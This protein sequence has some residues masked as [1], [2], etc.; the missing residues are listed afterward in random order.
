MLDPLDVRMPPPEVP[1]PQHTLLPRRAQER[2]KHAAALAT[3]APVGESTLRR[4]AVDD[5]IDAARRQYPSLF[6]SKL[7]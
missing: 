3:G 7:F 2:L 6:R 1:L 5:A 4:Q